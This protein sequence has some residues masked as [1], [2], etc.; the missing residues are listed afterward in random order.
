MRND[1]ERAEQSTHQLYEQTMRNCKKAD[2]MS[3]IAIA[4]AILSILINV[5]TGIDKI[6]NFVQHLLSYL[7]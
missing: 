7:H 5:L 1:T 2:I 3:N 4:C 6:E